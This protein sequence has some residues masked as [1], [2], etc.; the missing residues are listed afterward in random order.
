MGLQLGIHGGNL[1]EVLNLSREA[2][3]EAEVALQCSFAWDLSE[4]LGSICP[5]GRAIPELWLQTTQEGSVH[6]L[7][8]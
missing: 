7:E 4:M 3:T 6:K 5:T 8:L 2:L 1:W